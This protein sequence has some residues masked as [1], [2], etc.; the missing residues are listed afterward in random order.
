V[1]NNSHVVVQWTIDN[2]DFEVYELEE[3]FEFAIDMYQ[4]E[5]GMSSVVLPRTL[6]WALAAN[7]LDRIKKHT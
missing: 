3:G 4:D 6:A 1:S 5:F 2:V 7:I